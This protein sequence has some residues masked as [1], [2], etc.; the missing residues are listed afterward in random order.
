MILT[1]WKGKVHEILEWV[2]RLAYVNLLWLCGILAGFIVAGVFPATIA[3][4]A[5]IRKW[6]Q[7]EEDLKAASFFWKTYKSELL[8]GNAFGYI[9]VILGL[10]LYFDLLFFRGFSNVMSLIFTYITF[11]IGVIYICSFLISLSMYVH[12]DQK[13]FQVVK[14][15]V[16]LA[17]SRPI[18]AILFVISFYLPYYIVFKFPGLLLFFSG[19]F[20]AFCMLSV[21]LKLFDNFNDNQ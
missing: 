2:T 3:L 20:I 8:K 9:W 19:S 11:I 5:V 12:Y 10:I 18:A 6:L 21:S 15:S 7:K 13:I 16:L 17:L 1:G 4:F 14:N